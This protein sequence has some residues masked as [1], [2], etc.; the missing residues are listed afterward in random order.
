MK[1]TAKAAV[2]RVIHDLILADGI[3][4][5]RE[6]ELLST[7]YAEYGAKPVDVLSA[8]ECTL[9]E[10]LSIL[11]EAD[12]AL[13]HKLLTDCLRLSMSDNICAREEAMLLLALR[14]SLTLNLTGHDGVISVRGSQRIQLE[15][16]QV[17][18]VESEYDEEVN[19]SISEQFREIS[20]ELRLAGFDF[21]YLPQIA[22]NYRDMSDDE[23][24]K[25]GHFLY[26]QVNDERLRTLILQLR[27]LSTARFCR[28]QLPRRSISRD[29]WTSVRRCCSK[30]MSRSWATSR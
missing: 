27:D 24:L 19:A 8:D 3:L 25:L 21:V 28:E 5:T 26:P 9:A 29:W 22:S 12:P 14:S 20:T 2:V 13:R 23:L 10:A 11:S 30:S 1:P 16:F 15:N 6:M 18:Y 4:D 17:L 7:L